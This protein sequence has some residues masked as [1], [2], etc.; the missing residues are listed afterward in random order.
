MSWVSL[1]EARAFVK[2]PAEDDELVEALL[3]RACAFV[4]RHTGR[5]F[6]PETVSELHSGSGTHE[7]VLRR[8]PVLV[9]GEVRDLFLGRLV[10]PEEL[11]VEEGAGILFRRRRWAWGDRRFEITYTAGYEP[12]PEDAKQAALLVT[13]SWYAR[14]GRDPALQSESLGDYRYTLA[15][16]AEGGLP[17]QAERLLRPYREVVI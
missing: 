9:L 14:V 1:E 3:E 17:P 13:A 12:V 7:L 10:D 16:G 2:H 11:I 5:V 6:A 4:E 15:P 8:R